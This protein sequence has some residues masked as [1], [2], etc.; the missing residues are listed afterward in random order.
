M[1]TTVKTLFEKGHS[2][3]RI[4]EILGIDRK[5]VRK[6]LKQPDKETHIEKSHILQ[7]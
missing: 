6:I 1:Q 2:K 4:G 3:T 5:T 7:C